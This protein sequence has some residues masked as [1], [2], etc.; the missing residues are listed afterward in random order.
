MEPATKPKIQT[1]WQGGKREARTNWHFQ[2]DLEYTV[3]SRWANTGGERV[4]YLLVHCRWMEGKLRKHFPE[5]IF[6]ILSHKMLM[7][8][9]SKTRVNKSQPAPCFFITHKLKVSFPIFNS[10]VK[11]KI[12]TIIKFYDTWKWFEI[13]ISVSTNQVDLEPSHTHSSGH[14]LDLLSNQR[15][16][17]VVS[18]EIIG[19]TWSEILSSSLQIKLS[20]PWPRSLGH[21]PHWSRLLERH[22]SW[23]PHEC[24]K[25]PA[26]PRRAAENG[27]LVEPK[28]SQTYV[29]MKSFTHIRSMNILHNTLM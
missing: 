24:C 12:K 20:N 16:I 19:S 11:K 8:L 17:W 13:Q 28:T 27:D 2:T 9:G 15:Q 29:T 18:T 23:Q 22:S 4:R 21:A 3:P 14:C 26:Q 6:L 10:W 5:G 25:R 1:A 7:I